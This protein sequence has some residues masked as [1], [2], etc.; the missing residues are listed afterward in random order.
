[1]QLTSGVD[2]WVGCGSAGP[3]GG[4]TVGELSV[5]S[6]SRI[7]R[8]AVIALSRRSMAVTPTMQRDGDVMEKSR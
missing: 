6:R 2:T 4:R 5:P 7:C 3:R 1:M 8:R